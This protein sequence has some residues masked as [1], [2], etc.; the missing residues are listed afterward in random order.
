MI[1]IDPAYYRPTEVEYLLGD[2]SKAREE[3][4]WTPK[5]DFPQ[6]VKMMVQHDLQEVRSAR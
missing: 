6:L 1:E 4:G 2:A 3:L 5:V